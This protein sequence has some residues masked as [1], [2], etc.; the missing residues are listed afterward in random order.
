MAKKSISD[1]HMETAKGLPS[2]HSYGD[3][4][5]ATAK[6]LDTDAIDS[7]VHMETARTGPKQGAGFEL[8]E[9]EL[10]ESPEIK[11]KATVAQL[12]M[13]FWLK[14]LTMN[15]LTNLVDFLD[16]YF[17]SLGY[18]ANRKERR[19]RFDQDTAARGVKGPEFAK[20]F[21]SYCG[22]ERVLLRKRRAKLK[23]DQFYIIA[24]VGQ[25]GYGEVYLARKK[26]S[27]EICAL[28]K[29]RKRTLHKMDEVRFP[30][31]KC[32]LRLID[33]TDSTRTR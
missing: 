13:L 27:S 21:R 28:K 10:L 24:Q 15:R 17:Q 30:P 1:I 26:D 29:M 12:C 23:V 6:G 20:E 14:G 7:D 4:H 31:C 11:R 8:W 9:K 25:G 2:L 18:L 32:A 33:L 5:M 3:I 16:Y 19:A 22:R